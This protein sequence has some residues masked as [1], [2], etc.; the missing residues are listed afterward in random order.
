MAR[1]IRT[2]ED[3]NAIS[4]EVEDHADGWVTHEGPVD[5]EVWLD[6][7]EVDL[8][9]DLGEDL[10]APGIKRVLA[11]GRRVRKEARV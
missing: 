11:I 6:R 2:R 8:D 3:A 7:L 1:L 4:A 10:Q 9:L 5:F